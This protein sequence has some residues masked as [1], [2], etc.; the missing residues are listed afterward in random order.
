MRQSTTSGLS[1][2]YSNFVMFA[3]YAVIVYFMGVEIDRGWADF[4]DSLKAFMAILLAAMGMAQ[5]GSK[6]GC[7]QEVCW[8]RLG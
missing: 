1:F 7:W 8:K 5:V 6:R 3:M 4:G 2:S